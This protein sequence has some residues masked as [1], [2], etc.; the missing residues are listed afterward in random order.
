MVSRR[1]SFTAESLDIYKDLVKTAEA[2]LQD[3]LESI[4]EKLES[5]LEQNV[6]ESDLGASE[7]QSIQEERLSMEKC[8]QICTRLS[9]HISQIQLRPKHKAGS[10][11]SIDLDAETL[12]YE[13]LRECRESLVRTTE[14]LHG[15]EKDI[16]NRFIDKSKSAITSEEELADLTRLRDERE[17]IYQ[18]MD[19]CFKAMNNLKENI[20]TIDNYATGDAIQFM[21]STSGKTIHGK[22]RGLGW[23]TRQ[24]GGHLSD[25]SL[26]EITRA[27]TSITIQTSGTEGQTLRD[28]LSSSRDIHE[29]T[30]VESPFESPFGERYGQ[31]FKLTLKP[32]RDIS[33]APVGP[34]ESRTSDL[35]R[36]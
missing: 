16:F 21:V 12:T 8:L 26:Q 29:E 25:E 6:K 27:L 14:K 5:L 24:V 2:G 31:G 13:G 19:I 34:A 17:A 1:S 18:G 32:T 22:N 7:I 3:R 9:E 4:N 35:P 23:R 10:D 33:T 11:V 15:Y 28:E 20:S 30:K 36:E